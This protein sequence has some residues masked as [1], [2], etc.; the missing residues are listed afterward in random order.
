MR[1]LLI[2]KVIF[3]LSKRSIRVLFEAPGFSII[4]SS[5]MSN[6][7]YTYVMIAGYLHI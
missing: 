3:K 4:K 7:S 1:L 2:F 6:V 5:V